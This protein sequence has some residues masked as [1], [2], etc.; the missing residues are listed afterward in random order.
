M[1][2]PRPRPRLRRPV[3]ELVAPRSRQRCARSR[4][5]SSPRSRPIAVH[6]LLVLAV[7]AGPL[8]A[9][10]AHCS[11]TLVRTGNLVLADAWVGLRL[12][13]R[14]GLGLGAAGVALA[15]C[16][17]RSRSRFYT[18][19]SRRL[20]VRVPHALSRRRSSASTR[21]C[22]T[23]VAV[24]EP[25]LPLASGR[26][27]QRPRWRRTEAGRDPADRARAPSRRTSPASPPRSCR[28]SRSPSPTHFVA[29]AHFVLPAEVREV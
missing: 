8:A 9:A 29:V 24:A 23:T 25:G 10:L 21:P 26:A 14:R 11:V 28:F 17:A 20:A 12:H 13:W 2:A 3:P 22:W 5:S 27:G 7:L 19:T 15:A 16:S 6:A 1:R 18:R 4:R